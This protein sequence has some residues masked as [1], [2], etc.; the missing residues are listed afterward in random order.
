MVFT[1]GLLF[2]VLSTFLSACDLNC[3]AMKKV[4]LP[5]KETPWP[6]IITMIFDF[7][8][9]IILHLLF[10]VS[11]AVAEN[12]W[13]GSRLCAAY[14]ALADLQC[15]LLHTDL[16]WNQL[17]ARCK[18]KWLASLHQRPCKRCGH[19]PDED[20]PVKT[21]RRARATPCTPADAGRRESGASGA[22][23]SQAVRLEQGL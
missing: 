3:Y 20:V 15:S 4:N 21:Q 19:Q 6:R 22:P 2:L 9:A 5:D 23:S 1:V 16:F 13:R 18:K 10:W 8:L 7:L 11:A 14:A 17:V 12:M